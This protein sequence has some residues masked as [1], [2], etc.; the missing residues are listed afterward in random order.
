M[1][2]LSLVVVLV[3]GLALPAG[4]YA[5][6][7]VVKLNPPTM[8]YGAATDILSSS[9]GRVGLRPLRELRNLPGTVVVEMPP[10][11]ARLLSS[12]GYEVEAIPLRRAADSVPWS[13][14]RENQRTL[15]LD[16]DDS[17][18]YSGQGVTIFVLDTGII[19]NTVEFG[20]RLVGGTDYL[21][22]AKGIYESCGITYTHA[23][24]VASNAAGSLFGVA[25]GASIYLM[26]IIRCDG[27]VW[28][29]AEM[30]ALD[31]LITWRKSNPTAHA[32]VNMSYAG[33]GHFTTEEALL[34]MLSDLSVPLVAAAANDDADTCAYG[35]AG[36]P[37]VIAVGATNINDEKAK[38]SNWGSC[39]ALFAPGDSVPSD[40]GD[41][42]KCCWFGF[43]T[44]FSSPAVAGEIALLYEQMPDLS[45]SEV[46]SVLLANAD[47]GALK[48]DLGTG[49]PNLFLYTG[50]VEEE[51][52]KLI[53]RWFP[54]EHRFTIQVGISL[55]GN[56][57]PF[58][59][60]L[61]FRGLAREGH[62]QGAPFATV[63][64]NQG[65][66]IASI[67]GFS[68]APA[69]VCLTTRAGTVYQHFVR[70]LP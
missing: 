33:N 31:D 56:G 16:G 13:L 12:T 11:T 55:N 48:G 64:L 1:R 39:V 34:K 38:F 20:D 68:R 69:N 2:Q 50:G 54:S 49:S 53:P 10:E 36:Y 21:P 22:D 61:L 6:E 18:P 60:A 19:R 25:P 28:G 58:D 14:D 57:T 23:T 7:Y 41:G 66:G 44:S 70:T 32:V 47:H 40:F 9:F 63:H 59:H 26:R 5:E 37:N 65:N 24:G 3:A 45:L 15:P 4:L 27:S 43:G 8:V 30:S 35:P 62:C 29:P 67:S 52:T 17:H 42:S 46:R 51:V